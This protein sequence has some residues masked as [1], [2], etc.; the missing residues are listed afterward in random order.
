[1]RHLHADFADIRLA[2]QW[3]VI[4]M[5]APSFF[6]GQIIRR[7]G[8]KTTL[9]AGFALL[10]GCMVL[11]LAGGGHGLMTLSLVVLG[12]GWNLTYVGGGALLTQ[13]L[14]GSPVAFQV[15][16]KNDLVIALSA[17]MGAFAPSLLFSSVGWG[18]TNVVCLVLCVA[19][20]IAMGVGLGKG[21]QPRPATS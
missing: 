6:T 8:I 17:T 13:A 15:Q 12:L 16:G 18:G 20:W 5:F 9:H 11:N 10:L 1:M 14:H 19:V 2:I 21:R 7:L 3:H 4:A